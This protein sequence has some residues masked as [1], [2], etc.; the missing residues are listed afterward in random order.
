MEWVEVKGK[1]VDVAVEVAMQELNITD[2]S[3]VAVE[4]VQEP[5]K[6]FLGIGGKDAI[7]R[8]KPA[9]DKGKRRRRTRKGGEGQNRAGRSERGS[10]TSPS[11]AAMGASRAT[12]SRVTASRVTASRGIV[13]RAS[14][15]LSRG[16]PAIGSRVK[17]R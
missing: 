14:D 16:L 2:R 6:G 3:R 7:V 11:V 8:V 1:T 4:V 9:V 5:E 17:G 13:N 15:R 12:A 10:G